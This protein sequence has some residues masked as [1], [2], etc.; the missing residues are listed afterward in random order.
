MSKKLFKLDDLSN[1]GCDVE[2][3]TPE[4][5]FSLGLKKFTLMDQIWV[6]KEWGTVQDWENTLFP[7]DENYS[8]GAWIEALLK[9]F[10][11]LLEDKSK[12]PT[13]ESLGETLEVSVE[14]L[15]GMQKALLY[16]LNGSQPLLDEFDKQ[17]KKNM[18]PKKKKKAKTKRTGAR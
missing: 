4:G 18:S 14:V 12:F 1:R 8:E 10:H 9:T 15:T 7:K 11:R 3:N 17:V 2:F 16:V 5:S 6:E 13:W